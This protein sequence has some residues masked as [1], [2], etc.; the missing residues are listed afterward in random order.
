MMC[1]AEHADY[2]DVF[3][4]DFEKVLTTMIDN[5]IE[6]K[7]EQDIKDSLALETMAHVQFA[8]QKCA[9]FHGRSEFLKQV[10]TK[11]TDPGNK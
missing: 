7:A 8:K 10:K 1:L 3:C 4:S 9:M 11:V 5:G 2:I 6:A